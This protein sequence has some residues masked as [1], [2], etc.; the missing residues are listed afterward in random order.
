MTTRLIRRGRQTSNEKR[1]SSEKPTKFLWND[2]P[3]LDVLNETLN[4][5][6]DWLNE[7]EA[8]FVRRSIQR[9]KRSTRAAWGIALSVISVLSGLTIWALIN[10]R[11]A[12][13]QEIEALMEASEGNLLSNHK[14]DALVAAIKA[15]KRVENVRMG[16]NEISMQVHSILEKAV[17]HNQQGWRER[18]R[19]PATDIALSPDGKLIATG[20]ED[21]MT[22]LWEVATSKLL[23]KFQGHESVVISVAFSSDGKH[24]ATASLDRT[25]R[26]WEVGEMKDMEEIACD[27]V[28]H[29]LENHFI[30]E[31]RDRALC[32]DVKK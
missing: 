31:R 24:L 3:Y 12:Q 28:R 20:R 9:R 21:G 32:D 15:K 30:V 26:L 16:S 8:K 6:D 19:L 10:S 13:I 14:F 25:A 17:H 23:Q 2:N 7:L 1:N 11:N 29:Y 4:S 5:D 18:L 27:W 22:W